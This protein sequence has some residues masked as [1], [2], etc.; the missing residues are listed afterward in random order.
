MQDTDNSDDS[1][2]LDEI[3]LKRKAKAS[4]DRNL[5]ALKA[6]RE[7]TEDQLEIKLRNSIKS[8]IQRKFYEYNKNKSVNPQSLKNR[9]KMLE[10]GHY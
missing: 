8:L 1:D 3:E 5:A 2:D 6:E 10:L 4:N 7:I 9:I